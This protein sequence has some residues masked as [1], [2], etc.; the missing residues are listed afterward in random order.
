MTTAQNIADAFKQARQTATALPEY[1]GTPPTTLAAAYEI[2]DL[3]IAGWPDQVAGWKIGLIPPPQRPALGGAERLVGP[4]FSNLI[5]DAP[6]PSQV[7]EFP[8]FDGGFGAVEAEFVV[9]IARDWSPEEVV[10]DPL[11][12]VGALYFGIEFAGSPFPGINDLGAC[13]TISDF[14]NNHGELIGAEITDWRTRAEADFTA[15][16]VIDGVEVGTGGPSKL[17]GGV[18]GALAFLLGNLASR[19]RGLKAGDVISTGAVTGVHRVY[20]GAVSV[21][22]MPGLPEIHVKAV[23]AR[24]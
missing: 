2:Q 20:A 24:A 8:V 12:L 15:R 13:V 16:T 21:I 4:I 10:T 14:G 18:A 22:S 7:F 19:G 9:K 1:P 17:P 5:K 11:S 6:P 3:A 23:P